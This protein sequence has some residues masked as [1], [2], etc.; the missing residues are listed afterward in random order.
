MSTEQTSIELH[1]NDNVRVA[2]ATL[3]KGVSVAD[4]ALTE[5]VSN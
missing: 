4:A 2:T 1:E 3:I 5:C